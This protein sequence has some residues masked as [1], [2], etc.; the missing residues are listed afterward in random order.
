MIRLIAAL[1]MLITTGAGADPVAMVA[2]G[3]IER[4]AAFPSQFVPA[5]NVDVWFPDGYPKAAPYAV[6]Y[7]HDGQM[8]FDAAIT[9]NKQ[10]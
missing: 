7:I 1:A 4:L 6:L 2:T 10:E 3:K 8:L 9:W 5:R